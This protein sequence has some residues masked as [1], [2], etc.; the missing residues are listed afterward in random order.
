MLAAQGP[1]AGEGM[2]YWGGVLLIWGCRQWA[3]RQLER[4][5]G[6]ASCVSA[7]G[8]DDAKTADRVRQGDDQMSNE[9]WPYVPLPRNADRSG[10]AVLI[11]RL[12]ER[13]TRR[14]RQGRDGGRSLITERPWAER[15]T[16]QLPARERLSWGWDR[17]RLP[18]RDTVIPRGRMAVH[19]GEERRTVAR[20][21]AGPMSL[22]GLGGP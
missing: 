6:V 17:R 2:P 15:A 20:P 3:V 22:S 16:K 11:H 5:R 4:P 18:G 8:R 12:V 13:A 1:R 9:G 19:S 7:Y 21:T 14:P 10:N